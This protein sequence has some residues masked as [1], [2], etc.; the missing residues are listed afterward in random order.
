MA[1]FQAGTKVI[2][3]DTQKKG[4]ISYVSDYIRGRQYYVVNWGDYENEELET[5]LIEDCDISNVFERCKRGLFGRYSDFSL[6]NTSSKIQTS[7]NSTISSLKASKTL[8]RTYQFKPLLKFIN[9]PTRRLLVADEVGLGKTIEA[10]HIMLELKARNELKNALII[11]PKSLREKWRDELKEKFGLFFKIYETSKDFI[12]DMESN[13]G[14]VRA[15]LNYEKIQIKE[16]SQQ[17]TK[18]EKDIDNIPYFFNKRGKSLSFVLCDEAHKL[19]N[20]G[21]QRYKGAIE[22]MKVSRSVVFLTATPV[23]INTENLYNLLHLLDENRY[24]EYQIFNARLQENAPFIHAI[25]ALNHNVPLDTIYEQLLNEEIHTTYSNSDNEIIY[26]LKRSVDKVYEDDPIFNDIKE[27]LLSEDTYK[28][29]ARL[30]YLLNS[31]SVMN[32]IFSRTRK[33]DV[34][35]D[36]SQP[37][38]KPKPLKV[39]LTNEEQIVFDEVINEYIDDNS[40]IDDSGEEKLLPGATLGL[41]QKKRQVASSV[42]AY[43]NTEED[44]E[45]GIDRYEAFEDAKFERLI[46]VIEEV[47][48]HGNRKIIIFAI[49]R[50]TLKYLNIRLKKRGYSSILIHGEIDDRAELLEQ[51]KKEAQYEVLLSSEVGSEGLDMQFCNS[52][53]NY[54]LPWNPMVVEQRIG[55]IDRFG[56]Q[57]PIVN[58]YN[59]IV[60]GSIQEI[61][62]MRLLD[63]IGIFRGT[64]GDMEAILDSPISEGSTKSIQDV[65]NRLVPVL[66]TCKLSEQEIRERLDQIRLAYEK[67]KQNIEELEKGL[68]NTLTNDAY[69]KQQIERIRKKNS[70]VTEEELKKYFEAVLEKHL[71][72][73]SLIDLGNHVYEFKHPLSQKNILSKFLQQ[74]QT[75][76]TDNE[77]AF[78]RFRL[79]LEDTDRILLT[80]NQNTAYNNRHLIF[81]NIYHPIIQACLRYFRNKEDNINKTFCFCLDSD[82]LLSKGETYYMCLYKYTTTRMLQGVM[83]KSEVLL[84]FVY[85][86]HHNRLLEDED[87]VDRLFGLCQLNGREYNPVHSLYEP[88]L[89]DEMRISFIEASTKERKN[90]LQELKRLA[91][92]ERLHSEKQTT[93]FYNIRISNLKQRIKTREDLL[94]YYEKD[95]S[96]YQMFDRLIKM[97]KGALEKEQRELQEKLDS[98]N[99]P[100]NINVDCIP[101]SLV[102]IKIV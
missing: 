26:N 27:L 31:M 3:V 25:T 41:I 15:I 56:Q 91:E 44:L 70:Y 11:C 90:R 13:D 37:E 28:N 46:E 21:T 79:F 51:F 32:N 4:I 89:I 45:K 35:T 99:E 20:K 9:S 7:N 97:D 83:K 77:V 65:Y 48:S 8:F 52:M 39:V 23:M 74:N 42:Y 34:T 49:F 40:Y 50:R 63:R 62:Y 2:R 30:Q 58:I 1:K 36:W 29:R 18:S 73:C 61:I 102:L 85:S 10:G 88:S 66:Y 76:G 94:V 100:N 96:E 71:T 78:N 33:K 55:R 19:R 24:F 60:A 43:L 81:V 86:V 75:T 93:E 38:R 6:R 101:E 53:V 82:N 69:F 84:P 14:N 92:S 64:I 17:S 12:S 57:S 87:L 22:I 68:T 59:F 5:E 16:S 95:S 80:F 67:E 98:I 54:D 72:T 47:F